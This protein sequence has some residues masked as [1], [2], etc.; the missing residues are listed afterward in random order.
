MFLVKYAISTVCL[1]TKTLFSTTKDCKSAVLQECRNY[2]NQQR[3]LIFSVL[4]FQNSHTA[5]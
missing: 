5:H 2:W 3:E 4:P 1:H